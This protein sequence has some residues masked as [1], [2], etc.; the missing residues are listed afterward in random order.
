MTFDSQLEAD[1]SKLLAEHG[2]VRAAGVLP[3]TFY[4]AN[5]APFKA[6]ADF[7]HAPTGVL[8][9]LKDSSVNETGSQARAATKRREWRG[10]HERHSRIQCD[11]NHSAAKLAL[12]QEGMARAGGALVALFWHEPDSATVARLNR[13]GTFWTVYGSRSW[14]SL[15]GFLKLRAAGVRASL[16][17]A[18]GAHIFS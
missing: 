11:W 12:V 18:D 1:A 13:R 9:E 6:R 14:R 7:I 4:D 3:M 5:G 10:G 15:V 17:Y 2:I 16:A 8:F